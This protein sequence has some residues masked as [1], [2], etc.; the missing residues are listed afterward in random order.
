MERA[1]KWRFEIL[2]DLGDKYR[3]KRLHDGQVADK[4]KSEVHANL[5]LAKD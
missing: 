2:E 5:V 4:Q 3:L 1:E